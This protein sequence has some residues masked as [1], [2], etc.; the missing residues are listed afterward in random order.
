MLWA[1]VR[2][3]M[4]GKLARRKSKPSRNE[5]SSVAV[6]RPAKNL[7]QPASPSIVKASD[8]R[9]VNLQGRSTSN[10]DLS[11]P[12]KQVSSHSGLRRAPPQHLVARSVRA[13]TANAPEESTLRRSEF[14]NR[15][16][17]TGR[18]GGWNIHTQYASPQW[19]SQAIS[20]T[21]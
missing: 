14:S 19:G 15:R 5:K 21:K 9:D 20:H 4:V 17:L 7:E 8:L 16:E 3:W 1:V 11:V 2:R 18:R 6:L 10:F 12:P 13:K